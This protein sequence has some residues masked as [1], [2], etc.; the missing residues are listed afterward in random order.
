MKEECNRLV[1]VCHSPLPKVAK[2]NEFAE[3]TERWL[4]E[5]IQGE[6]SFN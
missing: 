1:R 4:E 5:E 3:R 2:S 6:V